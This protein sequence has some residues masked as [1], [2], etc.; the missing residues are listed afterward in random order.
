MYQFADNDN[1]NIDAIYI[2]SAHVKD[3]NINN[4]YMAK[5]VKSTPVV[6]FLLDVTLN[7][8]ADGN[9]SD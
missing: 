2:M 8:M 9:K 1:L 5:S 7:S 6:V 4:G 3:Q